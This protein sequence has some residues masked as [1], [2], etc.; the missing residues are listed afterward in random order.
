MT[1][2]APILRLYHATTSPYVR[3]VMAVA[4]Q[5]GLASQIELLASDAH[6]IERD[7]RIATFNPIGKIPAAQTRDGQLLF[8]SRVI[9]EYLD[10]YAQGGLFPVGAARWEA[11]AHQA[12]GD[13]LLDAALLAR[14]ERLARPKELQF[15]VWY[16]AQMGK[17][18][19]ALTS[20]EQQ[21]PT[22][23]NTPCDIGAITLGCALGYLDFRFP[24]LVWR[25][26]CPQAARWFT[27]FDAQPA[28]SATR[29]HE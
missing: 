8:D 15:D 4:T 17:V 1:T 19:S 16:Q 27:D 5:L 13:G 14:Y 11:L 2:A 10:D 20:I 28:M 18:Q 24:D 23:V 6:P 22:L 7:S 26:Q 25:S 9:C 29:P 3:K 21:A 12:L